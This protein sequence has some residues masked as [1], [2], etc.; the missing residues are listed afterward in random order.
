[1]FFRAKQIFD[2]AKQYI[3]SQQDPVT[4]DLINGLSEMAQT[5]G[6]LEDKVDHLD[7][8]LR[9]IQNR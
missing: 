2:D 7:Q 3:N 6:G 5:L 9:Q 4:W 8:R 1:M